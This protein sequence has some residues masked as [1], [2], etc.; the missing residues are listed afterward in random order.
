MNV[1]ELQL[2]TSDKK[3]GFKKRQSTSLCI[4]TKKFVIKYCNSYNSPV[5][6]CFLDASNAYDGV[7]HW[8][9]FKELVK[10]RSR[11]SLSMYYMFYYS[12]QELCIK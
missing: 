1:I 11:W 10:R 7:H 6:S 8:T 2:D 4:F 3:F 5:Y 12:K 9:L